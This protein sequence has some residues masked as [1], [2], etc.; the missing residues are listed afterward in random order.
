MHDKKEGKHSI[1]LI[2]SEVERVQEYFSWL[3]IFEI[4]IYFS[5]PF[6][7]SNSG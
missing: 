3:T 2:A 1:N 7:K 6:T 5:S 4:T